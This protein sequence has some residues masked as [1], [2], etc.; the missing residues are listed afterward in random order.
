M[1]TNIFHENETHRRPEGVEVTLHTARESRQ[2]LRQEDWEN[3]EGEKHGMKE[4]RRKLRKYVNK[5][6]K[7]MKSG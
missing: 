6:K 1:R 7:E 3:K 2:S 5:D 4:K